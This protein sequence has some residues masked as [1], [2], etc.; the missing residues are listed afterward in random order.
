MERR[1]DDLKS[2]PNEG[3]SLTRHRREEG[4]FLCFLCSSSRNV[5][6]PSDVLTAQEAAFLCTCSLLV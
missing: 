3:P 1:P 5:R 2:F 4:R 6:N